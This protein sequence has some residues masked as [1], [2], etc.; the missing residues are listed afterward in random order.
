VCGNVFENVNKFACF[1][2]LN[3]ESCRANKK[4]MD[5]WPSNASGLGEFFMLHAEKFRLKNSSEREKV[6]WDF[7]LKF[8]TI[9]RISGI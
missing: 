7:F 1:Y 9:Q 3:K 2:S 4:N 8:I 5:D 6:D